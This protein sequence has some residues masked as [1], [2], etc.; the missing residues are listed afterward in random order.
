[1]P[2]ALHQRRQVLELDDNGHI[3]WRV[4]EETIEVEASSTALLLC[5]VWD[6]HWSRGARE[7]LEELIPS[8]NQVTASARDSGLLI[9]HSPSDTMDFYEGHAARVRAQMTDP[10]EPPQVL[11]APAADGDS[12]VA[13]LYAPNGTAQE[14]DPPLPIDDSDQGSTTPED[15]P[16][17]QWRRQHA[18]IEIDDERDLI[19]DEGAVVYGALRARGIDRVLLM[20]VHTNMCVLHRTFAIKAMAKR[21]I[22][23][24]LIRDL[25]D[26]MYN[27]ARPPYVDHDEGTRLVVGY[28]EKFWGA[29]ID[30]ADL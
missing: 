1:M 9:V 11:P 27:P 28:V 22:H 24:I 2:I 12:L 10:V 30:S 4:V 14:Y 7:R 21:G 19:S 17:K 8:M 25:T 23:M 16:S 15:S 26:S 3:R 18:G 6:G 5:D 13:G 20:G 29:S